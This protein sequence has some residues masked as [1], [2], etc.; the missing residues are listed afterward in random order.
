MFINIF[1]GTL[2]TASICAFLVFLIYLTVLL[3]ANHAIVNVNINGDKKILNIKGGRPLLSILNENKIYIPSSS[4]SNGSCT[5]CNVR[6]TT[7]MGHF[8]SDQFPC[9]SENKNSGNFKLSCQ[10][11][12]RKDI[13]IEIPES[14]LNA[15]SI[16]CMIES[17]RELTS[18]IKE[19]KVIPE[20]NQEFDFKS[21]QYY[22]IEIPPYENV[23]SA[24]QRAYSVS[25][26]PQNKKSIDLIIRLVPGG[27]ASTY[28]F[29][30]LKANDK[31]NLTGPFGD[32]LLREGSSELIFISAGSGIA[33]IKSIL[34]E[35]YSRGLTNKKVWCF[36][37]A[38][39]KN[40][41]FYLEEIFRT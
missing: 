22:N 38:R 37:G 27:I 29:N 13:S 2:I 10:F 6:V 5:I 4:G 14:V 9:L 17:I 23:K 18:D 7:N 8:L 3:T 28:I 31:I 41:L 39:T 32:F 36:F 11:K 35:M 16:Y 26:S 24:T 21:G 15:K 34:F 40:D 33:P 12:I 25:S 1:L 20:D 19:I 30:Y